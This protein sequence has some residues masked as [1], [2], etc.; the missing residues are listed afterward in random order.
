MK[1]QNRKITEFEKKVLDVS[2][3]SS[4]ATIETPTVISKPVIQEKIDE[5]VD[6]IISNPHLIEI[7]LELEI[8]EQ[9]LNKIK[10]KLN[11]FILMY[12]SIYTLNFLSIKYTE[13][14]NKN[15]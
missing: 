4:D 10:I 7:Q 5:K 9:L 8:A 1:K 2:L 3:P 14:L 6:K 13:F 15:P 12:I 11:E